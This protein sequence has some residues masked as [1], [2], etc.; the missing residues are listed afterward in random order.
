MTIRQALVTLKTVLKLALLFGLSILQALGQEG[1]EG[2]RPE[3]FLGTVNVLREFGVNSTTNLVTAAAN[4][5]GRPK[6]DEE[7]SDYSVSNTIDGSGRYYHP[8]MTSDTSII[9]YTLPGL[10]TVSSLGRSSIHSGQSS[11]SPKKV[12]LEGSADEGK[13]WFD[14][15]RCNTQCQGEFEKRFPPATVNRLR[16]SQTVEPESEIPERI[17][18]RNRTVEVQVC[19]DPGTPLP[20]FGSKK[21]GAF[22]YLPDLYRAKK[23]TVIPSPSKDTPGNNVWAG[24]DVD[25]PLNLFDHL[26]SDGHFGSYGES[27]H[28]CHSIPGRR[29]YLRFDL[30]M[31]YPMNFCVIGCSLNNEGILG[32]YAKAEFYTA[33]GKLDPSTLKGHTIKDLTGQGWILQKAWDKDPSYLK[34]FL[35]ARPGKYKQMLVV[36][37]AY[38]QGT[39]CQ[40]WDNLEMFGFEEPGTGGGGPEGNKQQK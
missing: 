38:A 29:I 32:R 39:Q 19:A 18:Y 5:K 34:S 13:T 1:G 30:D 11:D 37:D 26:M 7:E 8:T 25:R 27:E 3:S 35:L 10:R 31:A 16:L 36:W 2:R 12:R 33:N 17:T 6:G 9:T 23:M 14:L 20:L 40:R 22:N 28:P 24:N 15:I 4:F 21:T